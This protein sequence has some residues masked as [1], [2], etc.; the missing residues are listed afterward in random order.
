MAAL[1]K[2]IR[3][4]LGNWKRNF[5]RSQPLRFLFLETSNSLLSGDGQRYLC[6]ERTVQ[7]PA[8]LREK[9]APG[10]SDS[11][12]LRALNQWKKYLWHM[13]KVEWSENVEDPFYYLGYKKSWN[14]RR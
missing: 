7:K 12:Y 5:K 14:S 4:K 6:F 11:R 13:S 1:S 8:V 3:E 9:K 2:R 10:T